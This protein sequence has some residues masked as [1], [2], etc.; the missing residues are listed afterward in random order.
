[1]EREHSPPSTLGYLTSEQLLSKTIDFLRFPL[2]VGVVFIH[3][4]FSNIIIQGSKQVDL[5][6]FAVFAQVFL[7]FSKL[8]FE[9]CVP[10]FFFISGFLFFYGTASF[11]FS[12]YFNKLRRR[13]HSLLIPY[14]F[15][16]LA[17]LLFFFL[18]QTFFGGL[19]SGVNKPIIQYNL[20]DW[21]WSL[22]DTSH[23]HVKAA[24]NLPINS[25][26]WFIRDL[27]VVL[28]LSPIIYFLIRKV[29]VFAVLILGVVWLFKPYF[30]LPGW[31]TV[32]FF[33]FSAGAYFSLH[34]K[35]FVLVMQ[36]F[37]PWSVLCYVLLI[38]A[39]FYGF[40]K[41][42]WSYLY[43]ANVLLGLLSAV[44]V[45]GYFIEKGSWRPNHFLVSASFFIFAYHR[46]PLV[47]IIKFLF[48]QVRPQTDVALLFLYFVCPVCVILLG[49]L[50][51]WVISMLFPRFTAVICGG[52][53]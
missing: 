33:F 27:M 30:Y 43:C 32:S 24:K 3:T 11:T 16:N 15:W 10:L 51:F 34:N 21:L 1:M 38:I 31:S 42:G 6:Q 49:L 29:G 44:A 40:G 37:L 7:L 39:A 36:S 45:T 4:D 12:V 5:R 26:F 53:L 20:T 41:G 28:L 35:N 8:V 19:L 13:V 14:I 23:V 9:V 22:W 48:I 25:P 47:F 50:F 18:A 46:L 17:V 2:I 52:R